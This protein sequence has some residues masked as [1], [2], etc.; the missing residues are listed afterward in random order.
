MLARHDYKILTAMIDGLRQPQKL[1]KLPPRPA[2]LQ[3]WFWRMSKVL[4]TAREE[5]VAHHAG[6]GVLGGGL[7]SSSGR[8]SQEASPEI[9][10]LQIRVSHNSCIAQRRTRTVATCSEPIDLS[11][12]LFAAVQASGPKG[13][14]SKARP[15]KKSSKSGS[16]A[17]RG[18]RYVRQCSLAVQRL[19]GFSCT[20][21]NLCAG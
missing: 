2:P 16:W 9:E 11:L 10:G 3:G 4:S 15:P 14:G 19:A 7:C 21:T 12:S 20:H 13:K 6:H 18:T 1:S 8:K 5:A 17:L